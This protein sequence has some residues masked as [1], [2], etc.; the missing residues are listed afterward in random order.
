MTIAVIGKADWTEV[1]AVQLQAYP[2]E[3]HE[4]VVVLAD[5]QRL[6][7]DSCWC[8]REQGGVLGYLLAHPWAGDAPPAWGL[9]GQQFTGEP[10]Q[11]FLHDMAILPAQRGKGIAAALLGQASR[12]ALLQGIGHLRLVAVMGAHSYWERQ[13]FAEVR[14]AP[15]LP[16]Y[17]GEEAV[18]M[19]KAV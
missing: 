11:L 10:D 7:P 19:G 6:G 13:G 1:H 18:L 4:S 15:P 9:G 16:A 14:G 17:Y 5:K 3:L 8:W 12:W 2:V